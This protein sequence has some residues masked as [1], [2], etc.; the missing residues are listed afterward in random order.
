MMAASKGCLG[1]GM[2]IEYNHD[3][4]QEQMGPGEARVPPSRVEIRRRSQVRTWEDT[5]DPADRRQV[6]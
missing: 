6:D 3:S 5:V 4:G 2:R 1:S